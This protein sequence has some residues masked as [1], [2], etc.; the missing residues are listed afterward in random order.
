MKHFTK[1]LI[2]GLVVNAPLYLANL[3][4]VYVLTH[5]LHYTT[6]GIFSAIIIGD[7]FAYVTGTALRNQFLYILKRLGYYGN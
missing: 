3:G 5:I 7:V 4:V 6:V 1:A 2:V